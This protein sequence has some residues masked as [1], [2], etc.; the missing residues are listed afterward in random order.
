MSNQFDK[1]LVTG[2]AGRLGNFVVPRLIERGYRVTGTDLVPYHPDSAN[3]K[4]GV[5]FVRADLTDL[6]DCM[7]ALTLAEADAVVSLGAIPGNSE[8]Q[9]PYAKTY[10]LANSETGARFT[11][12]MD[13]DLTMRVNTMG[14]Y[15][16]MDAIRRLKK[17]TRV[18]HASSFFVLGL[19]F[20]LSGDPYLPTS[21]P[22]D[23]NTPLE[24]ED[25]YSLSK[26]LG[27]EILHAFSRAYGI[28]TIAMRLLGVY[29]HDLERSRR[30]HRFGITVP[31]NPDPS[32]GYP[33]N[34]THQY[35]DARDIAHFVE[36]ALAAEMK[37]KF[38]PYFVATDTKYRE[39]T[40]E[41]I[42]KRWQL[43]DKPGL[44]DAIPG[45]E[46]LISIAKAERELGY[47]P[48]HSWRD[49]PA[50]DNVVV[51]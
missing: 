27:E 24:P 23:E 48:R 14:T 20:R 46:G 12:F 8:L 9:P 4:A 18:V 50:R 28:E 37:S 40:A 32:K 2:A 19:G 1:I 25:T 43:L 51:E 22:L 5:P 41:V 38:E 15:T 47:R 49:D 39:T 35:A 10:D 13:E 3:A 34:T 45:S 36:L 26:V 6:S 42:R 7:R 16:L 29:Y 44:V 17:A 31:A 33:N 21:L 11:Q 30:T